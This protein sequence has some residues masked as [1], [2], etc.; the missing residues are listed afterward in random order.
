MAPVVWATMT[1]R[2]LCQQIGTFADVSPDTI[3]LHFAGSILDADRCISD[4]PAFF[5]IDRA[6]RFV[7]H[8]MQGGSPP[9]DNP[10]APASFGPPLSPGYVRPPSSTSPVISP[11]SHHASTGFS[12]ASDKFRAMFKCPKFLGE[13]R[14]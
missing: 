10:P 14:N 3:F 5:S 11:A 1:A 13:V 7:V 8:L 6:L 4:P 2:R 9:P 12:A